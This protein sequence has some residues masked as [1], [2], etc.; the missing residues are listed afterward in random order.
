MR[1]MQGDNQLRI[2]M[3]VPL[4]LRIFFLAIALFCI[5]VP[6]WE[7]HRGVWPLNGFSPFF[8]FIIGGAWSVGIPAA[9]A[10]TTGWAQSWTI[11]RGRIH[12]VQR[13]PFGARRYSFGPGDLGPFETTERQAMEG[14]NTWLVTLV[15]LSGK[16]F[17]T[18]DFTTKSAAE[19]MRDKIVRTFEG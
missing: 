12:I 15:A 7:L 14:D 4:W 3:P 2:T 18:Y 5:I 10:G 8:L 16:R 19:A 13:N 11:R 6:A 17:Q 1:E 9:I